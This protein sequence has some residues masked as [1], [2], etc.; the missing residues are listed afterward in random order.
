[1]EKDCQYLAEGDHD[2][3]V[4]QQKT[5]PDGFSIYSTRAA[6][7]SLLK[8]KVST[9]SSSHLSAMKLFINGPVKQKEH[10]PN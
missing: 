3:D 2:A 1:M 10:R 8:Q 4:V 5:I 9:C 7:F 6:S